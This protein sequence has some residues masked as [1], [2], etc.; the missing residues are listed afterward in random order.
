MPGCNQLL[1][2]K[3]NDMLI[4]IV[5]GFTQFIFL[6]V[7]SLLC[8]LIQPYKCR[9]IHVFLGIL[10]C[11]GIAAFAVLALWHC[12]IVALSPQFRHCSGIADAPAFGILALS[13]LW[14]AP[15]RP[16]GINMARVRRAVAKA[17]G[18]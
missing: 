6:S 12:G 10:L 11:F 16:R 4:H 9:R 2:S 3:T 8:T 7:L 15:P 5:S 13:A 18:V 17:R 14:R 1:E